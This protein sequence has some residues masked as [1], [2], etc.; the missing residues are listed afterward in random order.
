[1][2]QRSKEDQTFNPN[3]TE[4]DG[5]YKDNTKASSNKVK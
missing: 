1:M 4:K 2:D 5:T 3:K